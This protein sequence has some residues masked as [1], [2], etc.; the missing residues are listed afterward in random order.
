MPADPEVHDVDA[1]RERPVAS[2]PPARRRSRRR[3]GTRCRSRRPARAAGTRPRAARPPRARRRSGAR[4]ARSPRSRPG[5]S[6][7]VTASWTRALQ[8]STPRRRCRRPPVEDVAASAHGRSTTCCRADLDAAD[9]TLR[10]RGLPTAS[11]RRSS[12]RCRAA[13]QLLRSAPR[14]APGSR[15]CAG[16]RRA[17]RPSPRRSGEDVQHEQLVDLAAVEEVARALRRDLRVVV[18]D[19]RRGEQRARS[20]A[21]RPA[22]ASVPSFAQARA[23]VAQLLGRVGER[24]EAPP[25]AAGP[26]ASSRTCAPARP[27]AIRPAAARSLVIRRSPVNA[28]RQARGDRVA[29]SSRQLR[30]AARSARQHAHRIRAVPRSHGRRRRDRQPRPRRRPRARPPRPRTRG[31]RRRRPQLVDRP[32]RRP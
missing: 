7:T 13:H 18:E 16:R 8:C 30:T 21:R 26:C 17:S 28:R 6:S 15:A 29:R 1:R 22:P 2:R 24:D 19:D 3:P 11:P 4:A 31:A 9:R 20:P 14:C 23:S 25:S 12:S 27:R 10:G 5:S 32:G